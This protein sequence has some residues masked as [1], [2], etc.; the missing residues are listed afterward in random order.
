[1]TTL[2]KYKQL[3]SEFMRQQMMVLGPNLAVSTANRVSGLEVNSSGSVIVLD[4]EP[5][6]VLG[7]LVDE[8]QKLSPILINHL[9]NLMLVKYP[10]IADEFPGSLPKSNFVCNLIKDKS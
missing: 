1:M 8:F 5:P 3:I 7:E 10:D 2:P 4:K 6:K 9:T